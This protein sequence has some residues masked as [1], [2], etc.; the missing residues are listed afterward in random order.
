MM[1]LKRPRFDQ[2]MLFAL[3]FIS[4]LGVTMIFYMRV[5]TTKLQLTPVIQ[6]DYYIYPI[7]DDNGIDSTDDLESFLKE[8]L[9][10]KLLRSIIASYNSRKVI[11]NLHPGFKIKDTTVVIV[12]HVRKNLSYVK[13]LV[14][15]LS[16]ASGIRNTLL[17]F[18]HEYYIK[19]INTF[20]HSIQ[21]AMVMQIFFPYS[22][23]IYKYHFPGPD[24]YYCLNDL[25]CDQI[26]PVSM[27][28]VN[29]TLQKHFWWWKVNEVFDFTTRLKNFEGLVLFLDE[30]DFVTRDFIFVLQLLQETAAKKCP[31]CRLLSL[32]AQTAF[33][34]QVFERKPKAFIDTFRQDTFRSGL[35]FNRSVWQ[36]IKF[37]SNHFC[38]FDDYN[39]DQSLVNVGTQTVARNFSIIY[40]EAPRT[41]NAWGKWPYS[42]IKVGMRTI[43]KNLFP[44]S[45]LVE[46]VIREEMPFTIENGYWKDIR[47]QELCMFMT[48]YKIK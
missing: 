17:I 9:E 16:N 35:A 42:L 32:N 23:E 28:N 11:R 15:S 8:T 29:L 38:Y 25:N 45:L 7:D 14:E 19:E 46:T 21:F 13:G 27:R 39:W 44:K 40:I 18:C 6:D 33:S 24:P 43:D 2:R 20:I 48:L 26:H 34:S 22:I 4:F 31:Q 37:Y 47:D 5:S 41:L 12:I 3:V 1:Q 30:T 10:V 36:H